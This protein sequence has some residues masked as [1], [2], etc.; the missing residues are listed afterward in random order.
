MIIYLISAALIVIGYLLGSVSFGLIITKIVK[1]ID[2]RQFASGSTGAT[3]VMR[4]CGWHWGALAMA[5]DMLKAALPLFVVMYIHDFG[6]PTW[7]YRII[8]NIGT[9]MANI[10][11]FSR[12]KRDCFRV[13]GSNCPI[14]TIRSNS[15]LF[16]FPIYDIHQVCI[17][18]VDNWFAF[19][20][21]SNYGLICLGIL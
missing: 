19:W 5:L 4:A 16:I 6:I 15:L 18:R 9:H 8:G 20:R 21:Y 7:T 12:R 14:P 13:V 11:K 2:I 1:G 10:Y 17:P 3:N